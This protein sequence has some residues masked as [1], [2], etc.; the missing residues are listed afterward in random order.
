MRE[1]VERLQRD[2][3]VTCRSSQDLIYLYCRFATLTCPNLT[4][5]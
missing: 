1:R 5:R 2:V 4:I 3:N